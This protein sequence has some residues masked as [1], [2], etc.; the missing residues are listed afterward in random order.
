MTGQR[1]YDYD[2]LRREY[3]YSSDPKGISYTDLADKYGMPRSLIADRGTREGWH[4][5]RQDFRKTVGLRVVD[6]M[7][8]SVAKIS[9]AAREEMLTVT[10]VYMQKFKEALEAGE[11]KITT[12]DA[13]GMMAA[14]RALLTDAANLAE[15]EE[16][17]LIDPDAVP[18]G[19]DEARAFLNR[20]ELI[21]SG[22]G[23]DAE[24]EATGSEGSR[25]N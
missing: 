17:G 19:A 8:D 14:R 10:G 3:V 12:R 13:L 23:A 22:G 25:S 24:P 4:E 7:A 11:I 5:Q 9:I 6:G 18:L 21:E 16:G 2:A 15:T 1:K 20:L